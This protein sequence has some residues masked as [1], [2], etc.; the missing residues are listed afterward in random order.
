MIWLE[1]DFWVTF[2]VVLLCCWFLKLLE[3][4]LLEEYYTIIRILTI[5]VKK[6]NLTNLISSNE[7]IKILHQ[8]AVNIP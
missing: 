7:W 6:K 4:N 1:V 2:Q 8:Q 3:S 5:H